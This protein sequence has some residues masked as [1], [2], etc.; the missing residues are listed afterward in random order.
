[1]G[2]DPHS[3]VVVFRS[4][5]GDR[6][7]ILVRDGTGLVLL[8]KRLEQG[9]F[10]WPRVRDGVM[11]LS[12]AQLEALFEGKRQLGP[13]FDSLKRCHWT[14]LLVGGSVDAGRWTRFERGRGSVKRGER[15]GYCAPWLTASL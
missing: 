2:V 5:S 10:A 6:L 7:T 4:K 15:R 12:R 13:T 11:R 8:Y 3:G 14:A 1:M 9:R